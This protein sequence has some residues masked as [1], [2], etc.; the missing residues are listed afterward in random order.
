MI[1]NPWQARDNTDKGIKIDIRKRLLSMVDAPP[2]VLECFAGEGKIY[3][4]CY[5]GMTYLGLDKKR[6]TDGRNMLNIDNIKF[7]RSADLGRFNV[8]DLD[9]YGSPWHQFLV[10]L[11]RRQMKPGERIAL[12]LTDG[13]QIQARLGD[14]PHGLK[15]YCGIPEAMRVPCLARHMDYIRSLVVTNA[16][17]EAGLTIQTALI[18]QN[19]R[20]N[21]TYLGLLLSKK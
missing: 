1:K 6:I 7:L 4:A 5:Q 12:F 11:R 14:L 10:I 18:G 8:F 9:A 15:P 13:L 16:C 20:K 3:A 19:P 17:R 2:S 21:M